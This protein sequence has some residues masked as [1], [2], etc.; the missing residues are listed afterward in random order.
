[1]QILVDT[2]I[3]LLASLG[4]ILI[5]TSFLSNIR[6]LNIWNSTYKFFKN[7]NIKKVEVNVKLYNLN[8][9][10]QQNIIEKIKTGNYSNID[11]I[12]DKLDIDV[13]DK[14]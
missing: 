10:E 12:T 3:Y 8:E 5:T 14:T 13:I 6:Y 11:E 7:N 4:I 1:M 2:I 9:E